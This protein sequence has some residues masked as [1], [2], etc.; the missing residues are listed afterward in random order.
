MKYDANFINN[1]MLEKLKQEL[2]KQ[3]Q[4]EESIKKAKDTIKKIEKVL[5]KNTINK[6]IEETQNI[7]PV[8]EPVK[9][10]KTISPM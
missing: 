2:L 3:K 4:L 8:K 5:P 9:K 10:M 1:K 6:R 7:I